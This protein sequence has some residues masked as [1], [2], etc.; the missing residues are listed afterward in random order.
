M[1]RSDAGQSDKT[2]LELPRRLLIRLGIA[3]AVRAWCEMAV[4]LGL[5]EFWRFTLHTVSNPP[6][7]FPSEPTVG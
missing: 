4:A 2:F 1:G 3:L 5:F 6:S 7:I